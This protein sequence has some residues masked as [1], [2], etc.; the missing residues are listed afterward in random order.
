M[1]RPHLYS[2][3]GGLAGRLFNRFQQVT[4][5]DLLGILEP[6]VTEVEKAEGLHIGDNAS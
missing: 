4:H 3:V 6:A 5:L 1:F 2:H